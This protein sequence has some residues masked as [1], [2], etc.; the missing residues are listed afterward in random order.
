[1]MEFEDYHNAIEANAIVNADTIKELSM[2]TNIDESSLREII[3]EVEE[4][5][6]GKRQDDFGRDFTGK[7]KLSAPYY[8]V[9]VTGAL[10]HTQGGLVVNENA[11]VMDKK[12][13]T[14]PN[15]FAG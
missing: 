6:E 13:N 1:M 9:K 11:R 2:L 15:L 12:G 4:M 14:L 3:K 8:A 5:V 10:F 7:P